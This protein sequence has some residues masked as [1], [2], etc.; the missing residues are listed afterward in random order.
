MSR[1]ARRG[2]TP[3]LP[4]SAATR[5]V[6]PHRRLGQGRPR[7][8]SLQFEETRCS[9]TVSRSAVGTARNRGGRR[10]RHRLARR[11]YRRGRAVRRCAHRLLLHA[12]PLPAAGG[13]ARRLPRRLRQPAEAFDLDWTLRPADEKRKVLLAVFGL[14]PLPRRPPLPHEARRVEH[15][16]R[17]RGLEPSSRASEDR[18]ARWRALSSPAGHARH[19]ARQEQSIVDL[20]ESSGAELTVLARYM[21]ILSDDLSP[22]CRGGAST[23]T[24]PS[25]RA[26]RAPGP[27]TRR[28]SA[29]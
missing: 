10:R 16:V 18:T 14:R 17:R 8:R 25:F 27:I 5:N 29:A 4:H 20:I 19:K 7:A 1:P 26:S 21:Q 23:S 22:I 13:A 24:T 3:S 2:L 9:L 6:Q 28:T 11:R 12:H 15:G